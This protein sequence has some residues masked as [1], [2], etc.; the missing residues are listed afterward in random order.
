MKLYILRHGRTCWNEEGKLQGRTD[1]ELN[2]DGR[3]SARETGE[4]L[5]EIPFSAAFSS[6]LVRA[7]ETAELILQGRNIPV[8]TEQRLIEMCFGEA[9]GAYMAENPCWK[10]MVQELFDSPERDYVAP[11]GGESYASIVERCRDF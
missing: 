11:E 9:E 8:Q 5:K 7:K 10:A 1:I 6:P 4:L 2:E 3:Q